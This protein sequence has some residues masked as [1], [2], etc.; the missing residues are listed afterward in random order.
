M[1]APTLEHTFADHAQLL[2]D[3]HRCGVVQRHTRSRFGKPGAG[4]APSPRAPVPLQS[5]IPGPIRIGPGDTRSRLC[6][7]AVPLRSTE[8][9]TLSGRVDAHRHKPHE[10]A[11]FLALDNPGVRPIAFSIALNRWERNVWVS[12]DITYA[13]AKGDIGS[14]RGRWRTVHKWTGHPPFE[15]YAGV[16]V[17]FQRSLVDKVWVIS[18]RDPFGLHAGPVKTAPDCQLHSPRRSPTVLVRG[19]RLRRCALRAHKPPLIV[20]LPPCGRPRPGI[21]EQVTSM[22]PIQ[23]QSVSRRWYRSQISPEAGPIC[24]PSSRTHDR[25]AATPWLRRSSDTPLVAFHR[26]HYRLVVGFDRP[27]TRYWR[28]SDIN[29][30]PIPVR[31]CGGSTAMVSS[32]PSC[33]STGSRLGPMPTTPTIEPIR[34]ATHQRCGS[35]KGKVMT[36]AFDKVRRHRS[37]GLSTAVRQIRHSTEFDVYPRYRG[38]TSSRT[39]AQVARYL[40]AGRSRC[41]RSVRPANSI[42]T[43]C[44]AISC[45]PL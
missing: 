5:R 22:L 14:R 30:L 17:G 38:R 4:S 2:Q 33:G 6:S 20:T 3:S 41:P 37:V 24:R 39:S 36:P 45:A 28:A 12:F 27:S 10:P 43:V 31:Q 15:V 42:K 35:G 34:S 19:F 7:T 21:G 32:S 13:D 16:N 23:P 40:I 26:P 18:L 1:Y 9:V 8:E 44:I 11:I 25:L 29:A